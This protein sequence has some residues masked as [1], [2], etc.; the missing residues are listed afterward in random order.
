MPGLQND[1]CVG[2]CHCLVGWYDTCVGARYCLV[3]M[4][5]HV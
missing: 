5:T 2:A 4:M 1:T 3:G